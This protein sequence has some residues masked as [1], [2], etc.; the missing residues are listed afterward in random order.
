MIRVN[1]KHIPKE[2]FTV[3]VSGGCD[4]IAAAHWMKFCY[5]KSFKLVHFNHSVQD[6]NDDMMGSVRKFCDD[7]DIGGVV[8]FRNTS[9]YTDTSENGM[10]EWR[11]HELDGIGGN[12]ITA[13]HLNDAVESSLMLMMKGTPEY[14]PIPWKSEFPNFTISH[15]FLRTRKKDFIRYAEEN[16][17]MKYVV[18][19]PSNSDE[20]IT[21]NWIRNTIIPQF[22]ERVNL[23]SVIRRKFY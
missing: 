12:F 9:E 14:S 6:A 2:P 20:R 21:R 10:R 4:S 5:R 23:E 11:L 3:L 16:D 19:D 18:E 22:N 7:F 8:Y 15:P 13:H 1:P 17:L